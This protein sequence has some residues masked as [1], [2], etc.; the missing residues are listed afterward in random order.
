MN[1]KQ[2]I[3][4]VMRTALTETTSKDIN[5]EVMVEKE[6]NIKMANAKKKWLIE[7]QAEREKKRE[8]IRENVSAKG[9]DSSKLL[10][11]LQKAKDMIIPSI[12][13]FTLTELTNLV[14]EL[15]HEENLQ[16]EQEN[17]GMEMIDSATKPNSGTANGGSGEVFENQSAL[18]LFDKLQE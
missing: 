12:D 4:N 18:A 17:E 14:D 8:Y 1:T 9:L 16:K 7:Y 3:F 15:A 6:A 13:D 5:H 2:K 10:Q 11:K